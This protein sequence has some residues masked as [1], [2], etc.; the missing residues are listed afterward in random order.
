M[1]SITNMS[2]LEYL[3][4]NRFQRFFLCIAQFI[5]SIPR[6]IGGLFCAVGR[7]FKRAA[8]YI[9]GEFRDIFLTFSKGDWKTRLSFF[10]MGFGSLARGQILR[11]LLFLLFE[12][13]FIGY[14]VLYGGYWISKLALKGLMKTHTEITVTEIA[15]IEFET[16]TI[17]YGDNTLQIMIYGVLSIIF[18]LCFIYTWRVNVRQNKLA[19]E[20]LRDGRKLSKAKDD[21]K[22]L[23]DRQFYKTVLALPV[24][25]I[26]VFTVIPIILMIMVAFTNYDYNHTPP[27]NLFSWVGLENFNQLVTWDNG[28]TGF[29]ATFGELLVWTLIWAFFATFTNYFLGMLVAMM[30]NKKGIRLK[31]LWRTVLVLTVAVPQFIS[32]LYVSRMFSDEGIVNGFL[33]SM[34]WITRAIP[35]WTDPTLARIMVI[36]I[37]IWI[38]IPYLMLI[39]TGVLMN[40]PADLY[41]S[42]RIDGANPVQQYIKI[43]LPYMLFVTGP[44][45]LTSFI[46]NMNNF[47]VIYLLTGGAP[48]TLT[49]GA[50]RTDLL[51]TWLYRLTVTN[52]EYNMAAVIG[53]MVF[54]VVAVISLIVY[55][56]MPS[57]KNEEDFQ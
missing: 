11:G 56:F 55:N 46:S 31:K 48:Y 13:V 16:E 42:A 26:A 3:K 37:N 35:F 9:A 25:G 39:A 28:T 33:M 7:G 6:K 34:G 54:L 4:L 19:Q 40:I 51:I 50:G 53:I 21:L 14:M 57:I 1:A 24:L 44:Y 20:Y 36:V 52:N 22:S 41:E 10:V 15:G 27:A 45:L 23:L 12:I 18:V 29:A 47:N 2:D 30:I 38:G 5:I 8:L 32:L 17:V 49:D 43:T